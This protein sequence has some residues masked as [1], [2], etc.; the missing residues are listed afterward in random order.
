MGR[1]ILVV[2]E[3]MFDLMVSFLADLECWLNAEYA[4]NSIL[5]ENLG[6]T[7]HFSTFVGSLQWICNQAD[8]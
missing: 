1:P 5:S 6:L 3:T 7:G 8:I 4:E 2:T